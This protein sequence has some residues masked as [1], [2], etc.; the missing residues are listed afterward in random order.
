MAFTI[1]ISNFLTI[2][3]AFTFT[4]FTRAR[5]TA[6]TSRRPVNIFHVASQLMTVMTVLL[7]PR[8]FARD[9]PFPSFP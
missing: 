9:Q 2:Y 5:Q 8:S 4:L 7:H 1:A 6:A 3:Y